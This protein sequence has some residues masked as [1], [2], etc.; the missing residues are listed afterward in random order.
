MT[1]EEWRKVP[2]PYKRRKGV[3]PRIEWPNRE[4][5]KVEAAYFE[6]CRTTSEV[7]EQVHMSVKKV[8][9]YSRALVQRGLLKVTGKAPKRPELMG[10]GRRE[11]W[12]E[13]TRTTASVQQRASGGNHRG[14][15]GA[16]SGLDANLGAHDLT[17]G[18]GQ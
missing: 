13:P 11:Q 15:P 1:R 3:K 4:I 9:C 8:S 16:L 17:S 7:A 5:D 2:K 6:G 14:G 12:Y 18:G 10:H